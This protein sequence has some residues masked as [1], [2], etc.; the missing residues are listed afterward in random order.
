MP[1]NIPRIAPCQRA[2]YGPHHG[3]AHA[4]PE[5]FYLISAS[6]VFHYKLDSLALLSRSLTR[7]IARF[8]SV[9]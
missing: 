3:S 2:D 9:T 8:N 7:P 6:A 1:V 4:I 5:Q